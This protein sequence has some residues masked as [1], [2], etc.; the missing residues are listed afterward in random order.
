MILIDNYQ[1]IMPLLF[2]LKSTL[3]LEN[4]TTKDIQTQTILDIIRAN[5]LSKY[6]DYAS[7]YT[8]TY[9]KIFICTEGGNSWRKDVNPCYKANRSKLSTPFWNRAF[10]ALTLFEDEVD[11]NLYPVL[12]IAKTEAD[13]IIGTLAIVYHPT[14]KILVISGDKD[15]TQLLY[16]PNID[17][18]NPHLKSM[19]KCNDPSEF[20]IEQIIRG[21]SS[22]GIPNVTSPLDILIKRDEHGKQ[23]QKQKAITQKVLKTIKENVYN[24]AFATGDP[25]LRRFRENEELIDLHKVPASHKI[26]IEIV[27]DNY[28]KNYLRSYD[29]LKFLINTGTTNV[30]FYGGLHK[31]VYCNL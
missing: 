7:K 14:E 17:I 25:I 23:L 2:R 1:L 16:Y 31:N 15:F 5:V 4:D 27:Y 22:D 24:Q 3:T 6:A 29:W 9:G 30:D 13:D 26:A 11:Q 8:K 20:L 12:K 28:N 21:D 10:E 19:I 18:Y